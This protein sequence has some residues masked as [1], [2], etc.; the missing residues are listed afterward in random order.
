MP[1]TLEVLHTAIEQTK[2]NIARLM[3][4]FY[5]LEPD[6]AE[7]MPGL[8]NMDEDTKKSVISNIAQQEANWADLSPSQ[9]IIS[10]AEVAL[11]SSFVGTAKPPDFMKERSIKSLERGE[12]LDLKIGGFQQFQI[13]KIRMQNKQTQQQNHQTQQQN[14]Q[15]WAMSVI[16]LI[17]DTPEGRAMGKV[18]AHYFIALPLVE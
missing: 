9:V 4:D 10:K 12:I 5:S 1:S 11:W 15:S 14:E 8:D 17:V 13:V 2:D 3:D 18:K 6:F 7:T 16:E